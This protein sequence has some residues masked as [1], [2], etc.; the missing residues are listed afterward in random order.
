MIMSFTYINAKGEKKP[1]R[2]AVVHEGTDRL[3]GFDL[4]YLD[5]KTQNLVKKQFGP[6]HQPTPVPET[7]SND[8]D[9][10]KLGISKDVFFKSYR[11]F[12]KSTI[13]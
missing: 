1:R 8:C 12:L 2:V 9:Y 5:R 3:I 13:Q 10:N 4:K 11:T 7:R 6:G